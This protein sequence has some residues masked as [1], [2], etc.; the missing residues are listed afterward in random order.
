MTS[1]HLHHYKLLTVRSV[2]TGV[3][4]LM[5][6]GLQY[7]I[8]VVNSEHVCD[9]SLLTHFPGAVERKECPDIG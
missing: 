9:V 8:M 4:H 3:L 7:N 5:G 1:S 2:A 6:C